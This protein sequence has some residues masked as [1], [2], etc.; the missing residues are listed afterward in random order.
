M[1]LSQSERVIA[2]VSPKKSTKKGGSKH[3]N[4]EEEGDFFFNPLPFFVGFR[5]YMRP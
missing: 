4:E 1:L 3:T 5:V 2:F